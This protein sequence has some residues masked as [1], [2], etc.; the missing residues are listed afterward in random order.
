MRISPV[1]TIFVSFCVACSGSSSDDGA[2]GT[3]AAGGSGGSVASGGTGGSVAAKPDPVPVLGRGKHTLDAVELRTIGTA[4]DGLATPRDL[5]FNPDEAGQL[6]VVNREGPSVTIFFGVG[7]PEQ[8]TS[9]RSSSGGEHF[10]AKPAALAFG[11]PGTLSTA[12][13]ED[14][15][16]QPQTPD[17]FM[18]PTLWTSDSGIFDAGHDTHLDMLHNSPDSMGIAWDHDNVYWVFDGFHESITR[19]DFGS[20]HG[21][22]GEDHSDG[23]VARYA[24]GEVGYVPDVPSHLELDAASS[25]L[26]I[27]DS[28]NRRV[29]VLD[30][31]SGTRGG[32]I[33]P[34]YDG[35]DQ[36][37]M[38][39]AKIG[40]L[41]DGP[42]VGLE[43][44]SGIALH[45]G[46]VF[47][48]DNQNG[49]IFAFDLKGQLA[50]WIQT[51]AA[52]SGLMGVAFDSE[53][54]LYYVD[55]VGNRV[56][57]LAPLPAGT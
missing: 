51:D 31:K 49:K 36:Y 57:R 28:G 11:A 12:Q 56:V 34:N 48:T 17:T 1:A 54:R 50:D 41:V 20:D 45:A 35:D 16:T 8:S 21:L 24:E 10:L 46:L 15:I 44:P 23:E 39:G 18:G 29:A 38:I 27:A 32:A 19:Y 14:G 13:G 9:T 3:T 53:G 33:T 43:R 2:G 47:V 7:A 26:Y 55:A 4:S 37:A 42:S 22:G 25:Q 30:T 40:T 52:P 6:W 5:G